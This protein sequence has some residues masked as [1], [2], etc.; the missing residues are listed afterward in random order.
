MSTGLVPHI[1]EVPIMAETKPTLALSQIWT[2]CDTTLVIL[3]LKSGTFVQRPRRRGLSQFWT[4]LILGRSALLKLLLLR[5]IEAILHR[6]RGPRHRNGALEQGHAAIADDA[7][8]QWKV[9]S[10]FDAKPLVLQDDRA[11]LRIKLL[12]RL[13]RANLPCLKL[14]SRAHRQLNFIHFSE[15]R[16]N[17]GLAIK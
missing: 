10:R 3:G 2:T 6:G 12:P 15:C 11:V 1:I 14:S 7:S 17:Q 4:R 8:R 13:G 16:S 5:K 9:C